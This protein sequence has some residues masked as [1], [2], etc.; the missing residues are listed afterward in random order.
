MVGL[1]DSWEVLF[2][3]IALVVIG[4]ARQYMLH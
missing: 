1:P 3:G 4:A 2:L